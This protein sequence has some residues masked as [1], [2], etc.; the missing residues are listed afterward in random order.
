MIY[1]EKLENPEDIEAETEELLGKYE[2]LN[3][4]E[5]KYLLKKFVTTYS[6]D[7]KS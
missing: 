5:V 6:V 4:K 7:E 2:A 3:N 1:I